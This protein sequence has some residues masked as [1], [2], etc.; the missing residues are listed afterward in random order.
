MTSMSQLKQLVDR[1]GLEHLAVV[2]RGLA[3]MHPSGKA[4]HVFLVYGLATEILRFF[5]GDQW[6][7]EHVF[8]VHKSVSHGRREGREFL[9]T[10]AIDSDSQFRHQ[11][12]VLTLAELVFNFQGVEGF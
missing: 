5:F 4:D 3:A 6:T 7:N 2:V 1:L 10:D 12:R 9:L 8:S 11:Q